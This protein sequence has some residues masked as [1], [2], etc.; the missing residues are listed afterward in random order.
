MP[1]S[2]RLRSAVIRPVGTALDGWH[3]QVDEVAMLHPYANPI[4]QRRDDLML[5]HLTGRSRGAQWK[6]TED[7]FNLVI[8]Q[9]PMSFSSSSFLSLPFC[10]SMSLFL[11]SSLSIHL[12]QLG[13][14]VISLRSLIHRH[15]LVF[16]QQQA[17][18]NPRFYGLEA[19][20][21]ERGRP[22]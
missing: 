7:L 10:R 8:N 20:L 3:S 16:A 2:W 1:T 17:H 15:L 11:T 4:S 5:N 12:H 6:A 22:M 21:S 13:H 19:H 18:I 14:H 9:L